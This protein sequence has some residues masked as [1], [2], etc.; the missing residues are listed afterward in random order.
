VRAAAPAPLEAVQNGTNWQELH[1]VA[2]GND[3][4][5]KQRGAGLPVI[6]SR[7]SRISG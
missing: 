1:Q 2:A 3:L 5:I 6:D 7:L 4:S